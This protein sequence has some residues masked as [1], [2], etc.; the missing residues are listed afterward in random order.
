MNFCA[1]NVR[2]F[3]F[4]TLLFGA[5]RRLRHLRTARKSQL[6][7]CTQLQRPRFSGASLLLCLRTAWSWMVGHVWFGMLECKKAGRLRNFG[8]LWV[9]PFTGH[10]CSLIHRRPLINLFAVSTQS[11]EAPP[12]P[13]PPP[14]PPRCVTKRQA[15]FKGQ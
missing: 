2:S 1:P 7:K 9:L 12:Q 14:I 3:N 13:P 4:K 8:H 10:R 15:S 5:A 11:P 6:W